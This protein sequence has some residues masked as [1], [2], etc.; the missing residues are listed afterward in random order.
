M[1]KT[2]LRL[3][4]HR[5]EPAALKEVGAAPPEPVNTPSAAT[6]G[7]PYVV[8]LAT[9]GSNAKAFL[10][11]TVTLSGVLNGAAISPQTTTFVEQSAIYTSF[12]GAPGYYADAGGPYG[13]A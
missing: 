9:D 8:V 13:G 6:A 3:A 7:D 1:R 11:S 12:Y 5:A 2:C 4:A 10:S